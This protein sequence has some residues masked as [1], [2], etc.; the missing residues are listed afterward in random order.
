VARPGRIDIRSL[1]KRYGAQLNQR[2]YIPEDPALHGGLQPAPAI[3]KP[4]PNDVHA[5]QPITPTPLH[6]GD[7]NGYYIP[8]DLS[9]YGNLLNGPPLRTA[10]P[11][12]DRGRNDLLGDHLR[13]TQPVDPAREDLRSRLLRSVAGQ[14]DEGQPLGNTRA[15]LQHYL[16][17]QSLRHA[18]P[19]SGRRP[20]LP[21]RPPVRRAQPA[22]HAY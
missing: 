12:A 10:D 1:L 17:Q 22:R 13:T 4:D 7:N 15:A 18:T 6:A 8:G 21:P 3:P 19:G 14:E 9:G 2:K 20:I 5:D 11:A 16:Q